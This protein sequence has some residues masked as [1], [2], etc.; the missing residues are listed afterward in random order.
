MKEYTQNVP[1]LEISEEERNSSIELMSA[2][3][4]VQSTSGDMKAMR[5]FIYHFIANLVDD[6]IHIESDDSGNIYVTKGRADTYPCIVSHI[7]TV[8]DIIPDE[9][10]LV[11][12]NGLEFFAIDLALKSPTGIGG[13]DNNG[14]YCCLDNLVREDN[15]KVAFFVDEEIGCV[16]SSA[17]DMEF[18]KDVSFVLQADRQGYNDVVNNIS[19]TKMFGSDFLDAISDD[20]DNYSRLVT[21]GGMTDVMQLAHNGLEVAMANFSCGYY[22]PHSDKEY[23]I[24]DELI[25]TSL[26]FRDII[27]SAYS[28][29][30]VNEYFREPYE[31]YRPSWDYKLGSFDVFET[32][33]QLKPMQTKSD[34]SYCGGELEYD[35]TTDAYYCF[36][37]LDYD[38]INS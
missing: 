15:I 34:C 35:S 7:D 26:L 31:E 36:G 10:Y 25:L 14:I 4:N 17:C 16:G 12:N 18:F 23:V 1:N 11:L 24:I 27:K 9:D 6:R 33:P 2:I 30:L 19:G 5:S 32:P 28:D 21:S 8:H 3:F 13:D 20:L 22:K 38:Y 37:C 29:G